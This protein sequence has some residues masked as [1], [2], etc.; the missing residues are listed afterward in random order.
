[1]YSKGPSLLLLLPLPPNPETAVPPTPVAV[2]SK[3][4]N[5]VGA[6]VPLGP[7]LS[8]LLNLVGAEVPLNPVLSKLLNR[9]G[10]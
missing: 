6:D 8:K 1:M 9:D 2:V 4:L 3:L 5:L 7:E 10:G